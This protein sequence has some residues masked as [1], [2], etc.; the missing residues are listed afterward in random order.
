MFREHSQDY[1]TI[2]SAQDLV[3]ERCAIPKSGTPVATPWNVYYEDKDIEVLILMNNQ[4]L[5]PESLKPNQSR[6]YLMS[7]AT[8]RLETPAFK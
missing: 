8:G 7:K 5:Y 1:S 6:K 2:A 4:T 3:Q